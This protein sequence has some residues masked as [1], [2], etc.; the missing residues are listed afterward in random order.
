MR[1]LGPSAL[2]AVAPLAVAPQ[3]RADEPAPDTEWNSPALGATGVALAG[4]GA[5]GV[6]LGAI[7]FADPGEQCVVDVDE[8]RCEVGP[9]RAIGGLMMAG[10]GLM[11]LAGV[12]MI[13]AGAWQ[14]PSEDG[15]APSTTA[16]LRVG[17]TRAEL[18]VTF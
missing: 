13:V 6:T 1:L 9:G 15:S 2:L 14:V 17:P 18:D 5:I 16:A 7:A 12:P 10:G 3:A 4:T 11:V 8:T